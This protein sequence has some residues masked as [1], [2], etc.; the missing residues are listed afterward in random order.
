[1]SYKFTL[2]HTIEINDIH[3]MI[4][5]DITPDTRCTVSGGDVEINGY[6]LLRGS[7]LTDELGE[8]Y[9]SGTIP[10]DI[11]LPYLGGAPDIRPEISSFEYRVAGKESLTLTLDV[12]LNGYEVKQTERPD[13]MDAWIDPV[14]PEREI[15]EATI[16]P[17]DVTPPI[18][19]PIFQPEPP[20]ASQPEPIFHREE[21]P[22]EGQVEAEEP[23]PYSPLVEIDAQLDDRYEE[24]EII[25]EEV[26]TPSFEPVEEIEDV[27]PIAEEVIAEVIEEIVPEEVRTPKMSQSAAALMDELFEMKRGTA[28]KEQMLQ[29]ATK[30]EEP[31]EIMEEVVDEVD[32]EQVPEAVL[33]DSIARQFSDGSS[34]IK[35]VYVRHES[36]TLGAVLDRYAVTLDDVWNLP[37]L[38]D[39]VDV[40]DCV[41]IKYEKSI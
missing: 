14:T 38:A 6:L 10:L 22:S 27:A 3:D 2:D 9:F 11:T 17:F 28:F 41:M 37:K 4:T 20:T 8:D 26:E 33:A 34:T 7:Y 25:E 13:A 5:V 36:E 18:Q 29:R 23:I 16:E 1:M 39:G 40:G 32:Q 31:V 12:A 21:L 24:E 15:E 19:E 35:M 30:E